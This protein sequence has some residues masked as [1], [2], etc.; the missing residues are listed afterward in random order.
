MREHSATV[1]WL[2][3]LGGDGQEWKDMVIY[4]T[5][6]TYFTFQGFSRKYLIG[7]KC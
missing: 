4:L 6:L 7:S 3:G 1:I 2:H 5:V